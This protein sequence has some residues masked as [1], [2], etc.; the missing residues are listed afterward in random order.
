MV[1]NSTIT[2]EVTDLDG[3]VDVGLIESLRELADELENHND[4]I[5]E[6]RDHDKLTQ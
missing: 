4:L 2:T 1:E 6:E 3:R 5:D